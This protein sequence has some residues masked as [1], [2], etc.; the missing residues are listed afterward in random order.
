MHAGTV[1]LGGTVCFELVLSVPRLT[2]AFLQVQAACNGLWGYRASTGA[3]PKDGAG[4]IAGPLDALG[5]MTKD[6]FMLSKV[7]RALQL[8]GG[9]SIPHFYPS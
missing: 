5:W 3:G 2:L 9:I 6:P 4:S 8:P 1:I 7:G